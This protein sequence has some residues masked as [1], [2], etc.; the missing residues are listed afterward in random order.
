[1]ELTPGKIYE[2]YSKN[3]LDKL[4]ASKLL[5]SLIDNNNSNKIR[6]EC[7]KELG[8]LGVNDKTTYKFL[9]NLLLSDSI[10][11]RLSKI[12]LKSVFSSTSLPSFIKSNECLLSSCKL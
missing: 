2:Q 6:V 12:L 7:I 3:I 10:I 4:S 5:F 8:H 1:M 11:S 9:E